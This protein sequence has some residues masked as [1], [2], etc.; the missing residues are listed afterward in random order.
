MLA[1]GKVAYTPILEFTSRA[2]RD[3]FSHAVIDAVLEG[4]PHAFDE[5]VA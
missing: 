3:A 2:V 4:V 1:T 5:E